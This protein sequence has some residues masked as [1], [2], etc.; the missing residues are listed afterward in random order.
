MK[1][2]DLSDSNLLEQTTLLVQKEKEFTLQIL[3]HLQEIDRRRLHC[4][5][6]FSSMFTYCTDHLR[7]SPSEAQVRISA[8]RLMKNSGPIEKAIETGDL[9]LTNAGLLGDFVKRQEKTTRTKLTQEQKTELVLPFI[10]KSTREVEKKLRQIDPTPKKI[11]I[12]ISE[13]AAEL[14]EEYRK[15]KGHHTDNEIL[16]KL[17]KK[18][19]PQKSPEEKAQIVQ[20]KT[21]VVARTDTR[22]IAAAV[23]RKIAERAKGQC[24]YVSQLTGKRCEERRGLEW[25]HVRPF[26]TFSANFRGASSGEAN[27]RLLC[28]KCNQRHAIVTLGQLT[29]DRYL[30]IRS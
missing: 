11:M 5:L 13:E 14:L 27:I 23:K 28:K 15:Q 12:E 19:L 2:T 29:M 18:E 26:A 1:I 9:N 6:G 3:K 10:G 24:E 17:L 20:R 21:S 16:V 30:N 8:M 22:Y 4:D 7:Y 25:D